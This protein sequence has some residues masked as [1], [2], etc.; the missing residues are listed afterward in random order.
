[1]KY[2]NEFRY[3]HK[4]MC[5]KQNILSYTSKNAVPVIC[6]TS[7]TVIGYKKIDFITNDVTDFGSVRTRGMVI[8]R[9][10]SRF[11]KLCVL[12]LFVL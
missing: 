6:K 5:G 3:P 9:D 4:N 12:T 7:K 1:M 8:V 11:Q 2:Q 10:C